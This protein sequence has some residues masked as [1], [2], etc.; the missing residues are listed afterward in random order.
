MRPLNST[1]L[2]KNDASTTPHAPK[3]SPASDL[4]TVEGASA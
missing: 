2:L 1:L 3:H 4:A